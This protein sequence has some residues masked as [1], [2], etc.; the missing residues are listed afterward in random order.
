MQGLSQDLEDAEA[1]LSKADAALKNYLQ[2]MQ[3]RIGRTVQYVSLHKETHVLEVPEVHP[4]LPR[5]AKPFNVLVVFPS[6][7]P[8][9]RGKEHWGGRGRYVQKLEWLIVRGHV[10]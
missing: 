10:H 9:E 6:L 1:A 7:H 5:T 2:Q 8:R 3:K 4:K